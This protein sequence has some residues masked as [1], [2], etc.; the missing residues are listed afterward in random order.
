[1][2][3]LD[4]IAN[5]DLSTVELVDGTPL[6][7]VWFQE[8]GTDGL[9]VAQESLPAS[10][11]T[12]ELDHP[13]TGQ[14]DVG[15]YPASMSVQDLVDHWFRH[16]F[17]T[18]RT[19]TD[20]DP[21]GPV[22]ARALLGTNYRRLLGPTEVG[23]N[24]TMHAIRY[25]KPCDPAG[26]FVNATTI[27]AEVLGS[28]DPANEVG[29]CIAS[30]QMGRGDD[31]A[32]TGSLWGSSYTLRGPVGRQPGGLMAYTAVVQNYFDG[33]G[34]RS[35]NYGYA[36]ITRPGIGD[37]ADYFTEDP[38]RYSATHP[39]DFGF[40]VCGDSGPHPD[41]GDLGYRVA[42]QAGGGASPWAQPVTEWR[43]RIGTGLV[44]R[45]WID[46]GVHVHPPHP[47][48]G[49]GAHV[50][51][52]RRDGQAANLLE[53]RT[54]D[55]TTVLSALR[56]D[57]RLTL[58]PGA[59]PGDAVT[60][61]QLHEA[62]RASL[63]TATGGEAST[64]WQPIADAGATW[65]NGWHAE[66]GQDLRVR[67]QAGRCW[68]EGTVAGGAAGTTVCKL[69]AELRPDRTRRAVTMA[70]VAGD[71]SA[72]LVTVGTDGTLVLAGAPED[73]AV[74]IDISWSLAAATDA[75]GG[76]RLDLRRLAGRW[77]SS[78]AARWRHRDR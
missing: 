50:R 37:G 35:P 52:D 48:A 28:E 17:N 47:D 45:D 59:E 20:A 24:G 14:A 33:T 31:P 10:A 54:E 55:G 62:V 36:A 2:V 11:V 32:P 44:V 72:A 6:L 58:R 51:I 75:R 19:V 3:R 65:Q 29:G 7:A 30:L 16:G 15:L 68:L 43:S 73:A 18:L 26:G 13:R 39:V 63:S 5:L 66:P 53:T 40:I 46:G 41:G 60:V 56:P 23:S 49:P 77:R 4:D 21:G 70:E 61:A 27:V 78:V 38:I 42:F 67:R 34:S 76:E 64:G 8:P 9:W 74:V 71:A 1:M 22:K 69:P 25:G 12:V 57:G